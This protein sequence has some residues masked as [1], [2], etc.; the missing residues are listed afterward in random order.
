MTWFVS[1]CYSPLSRNIVKMVSK[2]S[3]IDAMN[4]ISLED[5]EDRGLMFDPITLSNNDHLASDF[6]AKLCVVARFLSGQVD[7]IAMQQTMAALWMP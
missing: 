2:D 4:N 7:F 6:D 3:L 1:P 5:E